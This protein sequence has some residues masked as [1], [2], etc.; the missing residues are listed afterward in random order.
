MIPNSVFLHD[1]EK[2]SVRQHAMEQFRKGIVKCIIGTSVIGEGVDLPIAN[3]L[4]MAGGGKARSQ[5]MQNV[6]RALRPFAGKEK[7]LIYD[8]EDQG[9]RFLSEH[10]SL[11]QEIYKMYSADEDEGYI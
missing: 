11:R 5:V 10:S 3:V 4:V 7:A 6:G 9:S 8:F 1:E 2:D